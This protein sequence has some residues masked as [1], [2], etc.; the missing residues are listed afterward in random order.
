M[1]KYYDVIIIGTGIA[2]LFTSLNIDKNLNILV[3]TK[4]SNDDGNSALA[5]G[6]IVSCINPKVHFEDTIKA[7]SFYN[8]EEAIKIIS[9]NSKSNIDK[10]I[11]YGV[12]FDKDEFGNLK[13]TKEGGHRESTILYCK[14]VTGKEIIRVLNDKVKESTN[15]TI[16]EK[17]QVI[18]LIKKDKAISSIVTLDVNNEIKTYNSKVVVMAT[19]GVGRVYKDTTNSDQITGDGIAL[20][21]NIGA[22]VKDM[23]F[24]QF[25]PTAMYD[26]SYERRF[27]ISEAVRGEGALLRNTNGEK[28]MHKYHDMKDLAP[29]DIVSRSIF[30]EMKATKSNFVYLDITHRDSKSIKERFPNIYEH[31]LSK[32]VDMAKDYIKVAPAEHYIMG[33]IE[34]DLYGKTN[35]DGLYACG[36]CACTG[37]HGANR[38]AS[39]S[40]LEG[41][42]FGER[43]AESINHSYLNQ[44]VKENEKLDIKTY[45]K[46]KVSY[47]N[48]YK[49]LNIENKLR[50]TMTANV[51]I[52]RNKKGLLSSLQNIDELEKEL[53]NEISLNKKYFELKNMIIV[54]KLIIQAALNRTES[55]GAHFICDDDWSET[56]C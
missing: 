32:D 14:D 24:I 46:Y 1:S 23:E 3:I 17:T 47:S 12:N 15:I 4:S 9:D 18:E 54:S 6:G 28:F 38:L 27:L 51:S 25:H 30:K 33:G 55:I 50:E 48:E 16:L 5:Q 39:N 2:G 43:V 19:G 52:V 53:S 26:E 7:G 49:F 56:I 20:S 22:S 37:A 10:L 34:T 13:L 29:R 36:E 41:I 35:I 8:K 44:Q 45:E 42:V 40:L 31:C 21:Y 11:E